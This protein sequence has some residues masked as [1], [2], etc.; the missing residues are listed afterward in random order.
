MG[1]RLGIS[2]QLYGQYESGEVEPK[3]E[4]AR[5]FKDIFHIDLLDIEENISIVKDTATNTY[6]PGSQPGGKKAGHGNEG[7]SMGNAPMPQSFTQL[8][9]TEMRIIS[10]TL[11]A[12]LANNGYSEI[13]SQRTHRIKA[14]M[15]DARAYLQ[16]KNNGTAGM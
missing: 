16:L 6:Q 7:V 9:E 8:E 11:A 13:D 14:C 3:L 12:L 1:R 5:K 15:Q 2:S 4:F 10:Y